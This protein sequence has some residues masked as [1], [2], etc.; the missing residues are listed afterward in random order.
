MSLRLKRSGSNSSLASLSSRAS[1]RIHVPETRGSDFLDTAEIRDRGTFTV[2]PL[3]TQRFKKISQNVQKHEAIPEPVRNKRY[4]RHM[5]VLPNPATR[6]QLPAINDDVT[7]SYVNANFI[8]G[9][10]GNKQ[11]YICAMGP[12]PASLK[13]WWRMVWQEK[14][15]CILMATGLTEKGT[16]KCERYWAPRPGVSLWGR[17]S[18]WAGL[19]LELGIYWAG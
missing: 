13:N 15:T 16:K 1:Q 19:G 2:A 3:D 8:H 18:G 14:V 9:P 7:T 12:L 5:D 17:M 6:V 4:N 11:A 10:D